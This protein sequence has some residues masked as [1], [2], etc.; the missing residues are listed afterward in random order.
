MPIY[1]QLRIRRDTAAN[2]AA[3]NPVLADGEPAYE[4]DTNL[5]KIGDGGTA[6]NDLAYA[7][8][9]FVAA[10]LADRTTATGA[11]FT[12]LLRHTP[13]Q[14]FAA[15][16]SAMDA[17]RPACFMW[18]GDSTG[19]SDGT[20]ASDLRTPT[21]LAQLLGKA[22]PQYHVLSRTM[23]ADGTGYG[24]TV[25]LQA[26]AAGQRF[27]HFGGPRSL[28]WRPTDYT[29][30]RFTSGDV[31]I[32]VLYKPDG[33]WASG[34][35]RILAARRLKD[36]DGAT[37][38]SVLEQFRFML[39]GAGTLRF[40][41]ST[42]G[43]GIDKQNV[44]SSVPITMSADAPVWLRATLSFVSGS[45]TQ[46][47]YTSTDG[48]TWSE[49]GTPI[50]PYA[51][52]PL[53]DAYQ[54][55]FELGAES[56]QPAANGALGN[57][58][59]VEIRDGIG[60]PTVAPVLPELWERYG[61]TTAATFGGAPTLMLVNASRSGTALSYHTASPRL[62][63]ET[64][65]YGQQVVIF[66]DSHNEGSV[67]GPGGWIGPYR[68]WVAA[69]LARLPL[70]AVAV[71]LQN[72]HT[73]AW[74]NEAAYGYS[75]QLRLDELRQL[76][77]AQRWSILDLFEAFTNDSRGLAVLVQADGLHPTQPGYALAA[78]VAATAI[79]I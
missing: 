68:A 5:L 51:S 13:Q 23:K 47:F 45:F 46:H 18:I 72:P 39:E 66:N 1:T 52:S 35:T 2:W 57:I 37:A 38:S 36:V 29:T 78:D 65:N 48:Q 19:D 6:Y 22:Y 64:A 25:V 9:A 77:A 12:Q 10:L 50:G 79:G 73:A 58:Y 60:G 40:D 31:D 76:A 11:A 49:L 14:Q 24:P 41:W 21:R 67:S 75:H 54:G 8:D 55:F 17:G 15:L 20:N 42:N 30:T 28:R 43:T 16:R 26:A 44:R 53:F 69:V 59:E 34:D 70:A 4:H 56:W 62:G 33:G 61:D 27:A 74:A 3:I 7:D 32:R 71:V 63:V